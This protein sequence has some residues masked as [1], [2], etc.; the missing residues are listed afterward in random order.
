MAEVNTVPAISKMIP[1]G[2][3]LIPPVF[4]PVRTAT[5]TRTRP[6]KITTTELQ[7]CL[8]SCLFKKI[9]DMKAVIAI[10]NPL[11]I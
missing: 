4:V 1:R 5:P 6:T 2:S 8:N 10:F 9:T 11:I 7:W 3:V